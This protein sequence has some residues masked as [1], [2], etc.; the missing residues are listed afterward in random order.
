MR[1][2]LAHF[3]DAAV[4][5]SDVSF[6]ARL[7]SSAGVGAQSGAAPQLR[8]L[9][10]NKVRDEF[11]AR[12]SALSRRYVYR[13]FHSSGGRDRLLE[14][15]RSW[16]VPQ[17]LDEEVLAR[18]GALF[19]GGPHDFSQFRSVHCQ[20]RNPVRNLDR[21]S[22]HAEPATF[23]PR[24]YA[25]ATGTTQAEGSPLGRVAHIEVEAKAFLHSQVRMLVAAMVEAARVPLVRPSSSATGTAAAT[26]DDVLDSIRRRLK[27]GA[28]AGGGAGA[29]ADTAAPAPMPK[30]TAPAHGLYLES[31]QYAAEHTRCPTKEAGLCDC[32]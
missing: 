15:G 11:D 31:V 6:R 21:L 28:G 23:P 26:S 1:G 3:I 27:A 14:Q 24:S 4:R 9:S 25:A 5:N 32:Q 22:V 20:A 16:H 30:P 7:K 19:L 10:V 13:V 17:R 12:H 8:V 18:A 2:S 29:G